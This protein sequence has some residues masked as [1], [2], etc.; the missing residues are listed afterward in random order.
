MDKRS[1]V[2]ER[3]GVP[4]PKGEHGEAPPPR[5]VEGCTIWPRSTL[6]YDDR[7]EVPIDGWNVLMPGGTDIKET[8]KVL[9][10]NRKWD[11]EGVPADYGRKG[12][13]VVLKRVGV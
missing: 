11:V 7:G 13:L 6:A 9:F 3:P 10:K 8:D 2:I 5:T 4:L 12:V 1:V